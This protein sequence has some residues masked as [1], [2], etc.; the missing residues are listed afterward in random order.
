MMPST[1]T[2]STIGTLSRLIGRP[3]DGS[4]N[5]AR[6]KANDALPADELGF[7]LQYARQPDLEQERRRLVSILDTLDFLLQPLFP[8]SAD[9]LS[10][11]AV[12]RFPGVGTGRASDALFSIAYELGEA[13]DLVSCEPCIGEYIMTFPEPPR[14]DSGPAPMSSLCWVNSP[15]P[16]DKKWALENT[17]VMSAWHLSPG[18]GKG[19]FIAQPD[20]GFAA[21][22]EI[23]A[24]A[25]RLDLAADILEGGG[26]PTDPLDPATSCPGHGSGMASVAVGRR[27]GEISGAAP[28]AHLVP[29]RCTSDVQMI[30]PAPM[31]RAVDH[32]RMSGCHIVSLSL[33]G[34][35]SAALRTAI[36]KAVESDL[37]VVAAAGNCIGLTVYPARYPEVIAV[38]G[39]NINDRAWRGSS[40]GPAVDIAAPAEMVWRAKHDMSKG[41]KPVVSEGQGTSYSAALVTGIA[42]LW[43]ERHGRD[44][45]VA[46]ARSRNVTLQELFRS[47][48]RHTA[49][50]PTGW[51]SSRLGA[52]IV[53]AETL[54][55][56]APAD[57]PDPAWPAKSYRPCASEIQRLVFE[58]THKKPEDKDFD[59]C[60]YGAEIANLALRLAHSR[61]QWNGMDGQR[62]A[63]RIAV[64]EHLRRAVRE[65]G[66]LALATLT[67]SFENISCE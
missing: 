9:E 22:D 66:D 57:I 29:I 65:S 6:N 20:T 47:A 31:A 45:L 61:T 1:E 50:V 63:R 2:M 56:L 36:K 35:G 34:L 39:T 53:D 67:E 43:L 15:A 14:A 3:R 21:H 5:R 62:S 55:S 16:A 48:L 40:T 19:I 33:G 27:S 42:A 46:E 24:D 13:L 41:G 10:H 51:N 28:G 44:N 49:R 7:V 60:R 52:G 54:L 8:M 58:A 32:A 30:N 18:L 25:L 17:R 38:G 11:F 23:E 64:S 4:R 59:W 26:D 12:L 37:I